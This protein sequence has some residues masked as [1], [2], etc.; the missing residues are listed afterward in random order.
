M[1]FMR[2]ANLRAGAF[3]NK[4]F[5]RYWGV[6]RY[7]RFWTKNS[8]VVTSYFIEFILECLSQETITI[9]L[10]QKVAAAFEI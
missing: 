5:L 10:K 8:V 6:S 2:P 9:S 7:S 1:G 3:G 4:A